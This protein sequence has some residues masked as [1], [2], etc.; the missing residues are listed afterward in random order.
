MEFQPKP[1][2]FAIPKIVCPRCDTRMRLA[3]VEP[4]EIHNRERMTFACDCGFD[5]RQSHPIMIEQ[6]L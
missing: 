2:D 1:A 5:Y 6:T 4:E 3:T